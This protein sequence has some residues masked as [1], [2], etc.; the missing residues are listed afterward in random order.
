MTLL[1]PADHKVE[2]FVEL[3][4]QTGDFRRV[5]LQ[6]GIHIYDDPTSARVKARA[7][8]SSLAEV[9][10]ETE[11]L[12]PLIARRDFAQDLE[13]GVRRSVVDKNYL[14]GG[15]GCSRDFQFVMQECDVVRF[16]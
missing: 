10:A 5:V 13:A 1:A 12:D 11:N 4:Q 14:E 3:R 16:V 6:I 15:Q 8:G 2:P 7:H 9:P